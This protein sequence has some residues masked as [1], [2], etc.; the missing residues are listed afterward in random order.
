ML[1]LLRRAHR[2]RRRDRFAPARALAGALPLHR[3]ERLEPRLFMSADPMAFETASAS[4]PEDL[5]STAAT[6]PIDFTSYSI[7]SFTRQDRSPVWSVLDEGTTLRLEGNAW[8]RI[9]FN[10]TITAR[11]VIEFD[12]LSTTEGDIHGISLEDD[13][14]ITKPRIYKLHGTERG[15][16]A[17]ATS[18]AGSEGQWK[19]YSLHVGQFAGD[20]TSLVFVN[21]HDRRSADADS[22]FANVVIY[23][24]PD[25]PPP[26]PGV[27]AINF[28]L[29]D[30]D[31]ARGDNRRSSTATVLNGGSTL[32]LQGNAWKSIAFNYTLTQDSVLEFDFRSML[33]GDL[34]AIGL[35]SD[36]RLSTDRLIKLH[37]PENG[38]F[39]TTESYSDSLYD[40]KHYRI[41]VGKLL[42]GD[43][44][45]LIFA[46]DHDVRQAFAESS[47]ANVRL[48]EATEPAPEL[49]P[50]A[51]DPNLA[52]PT[53]TFSQQY[54][55]G[56][57]DAGAA[58]AMARGLTNPLA[59][60]TNFGGAGDW[61]LNMINAPEAWAAGATGEDVIVA[62]IDTGVNYAHAEF[63][64]RI[65]RNT[66][67][68][69]GNGRDDDGNGFVD[70]IRGW[71]FVDSD[72]T[73]L[74]GNGHGT[75]VAGTIAAANDG[76]GATGIAF[77]AWIMPIRVL[78]NAGDG[79]M[80]DV[81]A[82]IYYAADNGADVIN[83]SLG[84]G[85]GSR[86]LDEAV[87]YAQSLG[88]VVVM[89]A[90][91]NG[92]AQPI[93]PA[94]YADDWGVAVGAVNAGG[95]LAYFSN[96]AGT[97]LLDY[98]A[99]PGV[100]IYSTASDGSYTYMSGTSMAAPHVAGVAALIRSVNPA[101]SAAQI[102]SILISTANADA[103]FV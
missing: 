82:G 88:T 57:V 83:L 42:T 103:V 19:H 33:G 39:L 12:F 61:N 9:D 98:V 43:I 37:G 66:D 36:R 93:F 30:I 20:I 89:A 35:E 5:F 51:I 63:A 68:V 77:D 65:W 102:E 71:D 15:R 99:A 92:A 7:E 86:S 45:Q 6:A 81:V 84:S 1:S 46:N 32:N 97:T 24:M 29:F 49:P 21:D 27:D 4:Q 59:N 94:A 31:R 100:S 26:A 25:D 80:S 50:A 2:A 48:Y 40:W 79:Y 34:H 96:R 85:M 38:E 76:V 14:R 60:V 16:Y 73:P 62:V 91:N 75:H 10:Y 53:P 47:F 87:K 74:D 22:S 17:E 70:D 78:D 3:L 23:E 101:L 41:E 95:Q 11:T 55:Y 72:T 90:G 44:N 54:G 28:N 58:V 13:T 8:K 18:Y 52:F 64:G 67:E 56:L 69:A